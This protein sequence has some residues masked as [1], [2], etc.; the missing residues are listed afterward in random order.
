MYLLLQVY[1]YGYWMS[2]LK[3]TLTS[4]NTKKPITVNQKPINVTKK[5]H[6]YTLS[7]IFTIILYQ[8]CTPHLSEQNNLKNQ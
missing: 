2:T 4:Y 7:K 5:L 6:A 3:Q 1:I 8:S